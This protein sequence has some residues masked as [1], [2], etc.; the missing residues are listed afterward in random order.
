MRKIPSLGVSLVLYIVALNLLALMFKSS[1]G[2]TYPINGFELTLWGIF[3]LL[4][5]QVS[6][7]GDLQLNKIPIDLAASSRHR[8]CR[9]YFMS[10][11]VPWLVG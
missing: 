1:S 2:G 9:W 7:I 8:F 4:F 10:T 11:P 6:A 5:L 3:G